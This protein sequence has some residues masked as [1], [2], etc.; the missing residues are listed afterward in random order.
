MMMMLVQ[1]ELLLS[2]LCSELA[3]QP[4]AVAC[5][6]DWF[7]MATLTARRRVI[8]SMMRAAARMLT[9]AVGVTLGVLRRV[10]GRPCISEGRTDLR[11][12]DPSA[13][14]DTL[15]GIWGARKP[16]R[17]VVETLVTGS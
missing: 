12:F 7:L 15:T 11:C 4:N 16:C 5:N 10:V 14:V 9:V 1:V 8:V 13:V 2:S 6:N 3:G 17:T